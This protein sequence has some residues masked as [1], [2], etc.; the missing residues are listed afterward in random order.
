MERES[1]VGAVGAGIGRVFDIT[2]IGAAGEFEV[3]F[4]HFKG[5]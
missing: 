4:C 1:A 5:L 3:I 2:V